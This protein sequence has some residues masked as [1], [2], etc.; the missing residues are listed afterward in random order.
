M[1]PDSVLPIRELPAR[2]K[3]AVSAV[4]ALLLVLAGAITAPAA[5]AAGPAVTAPAAPRA[6]GTITVTGSGFAGVSPGVYLGIGPAGLPGF[7]AG[8][9]QITDTVWVAPGNVDGGSAGGRTA[10]MGEDGTF[11]V[12]LTVPAYTDGAQYALYT[13]KAHGQGFQDPSQNTVT[14]LAWEP[15]PA[16]ATSTT[17]AVSPA[18]TSVEG[19]EVTLTATVSP[20]AAGTVAFFAAGTALGSASLDAGTAVLTTS[21]LPVGTPALAAAFTPADAAAFAGSASGPVSHTVT[22][23]P[24]EPEPQPVFVPTISVFRADGATPFTGSVEPG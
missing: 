9:A 13:S 6:G 20:A 5:L 10:P 11:S 12:Q 16:V 24:V 8:S 1:N 18:A 21:S 2:A 14:P 3:A 22:A 4:L 19:A 7:Y 15:L 17:L 23:K